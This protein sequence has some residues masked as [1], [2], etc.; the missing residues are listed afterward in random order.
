LLPGS[1]SCR[2]LVT[3][4][5]SL[6]DLAGARLIDLDVLDGDEARA[7]LGRIAGAERLNAEPEATVR[8]LGACAGLP[9]AIR[10]AGARLVTRS[11]WKVETLASRLADTRRRIDEF[12]VGDLAIRACFQVSLG[13]LPAA[14]TRRVDPTRAFRLLGLWQGPSIGL[15]AAAAL[16]GQPEDDVAEALE[17]LVDAHLLQCPAAERYRFH[18]LLRAYAAQQAEDAETEQDRG[19]AVRRVLTWYLHTVEAAA[20]II[21]PHHAR[22]PLGA[23]GFVRPPLEFASLDHALGWC[24]TERQ[25]LVSATRQAAENGFHEIAWKLPAAAMSFFYRRSHW[26]NW[27]TTHRIGLASAR[28]LGDKLAEAWMLNNLGMAFGLQRMEEAVRCFEQAL[29]IYREIGDIQGETKAANNVAHAHLQMRRFAE[30]FD[31]AQRSL[32]IQ[33]QTGNRYGEGIALG[34]LGDAGRELGRFHEASD[35]LQQ[36]LV[37]FRG[38]GDQHSEADSLSDLGDVYLTMDRITDALSCLNESLSIWREIG[39][40]HG[41]AATLKRLGLAL[42]RAGRPGEARASLSEAHR[43]FEELGDHAQAAQVHIGLAE[44][45]EMAR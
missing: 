44:L 16:L 19:D 3:S 22:V 20:K 18:D 13:S 17:A 2:V 27:M 25:G 12:R 41:Q 33:R 24:E 11:G 15:P 38:L 37:I 9:L 10:I 8:V 34:N 6:P 26:A 35:H 7:L 1:A 40:R 21:S 4:R 28:E 43:I 36:A 39:E 31:A 45:T 5:S 29:A 32:R 30:A 23:A 42:R 14:G